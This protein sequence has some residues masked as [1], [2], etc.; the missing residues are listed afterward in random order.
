MIKEVQLTAEM[1][2]QIEDMRNEL[3]TTETRI[4]E[5]FKEIESGNKQYFVL[6]HRYDALDIEYAQLYE[7]FS[8][9]EAAL[10]SS[11]QKT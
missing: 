10:T 2:Q 8:E 3:L 6:K 11:D 7:R 4:E 9:A 1:K 5:L